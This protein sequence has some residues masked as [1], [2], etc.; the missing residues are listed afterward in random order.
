MKD[1]A[2]T[3]L[4]MPCFGIRFILIFLSVFYWT[5]N[6]SQLIHDNVEL[7]NGTYDATIPIGEELVDKWGFILFFWHMI[8]WLPSIIFIPPL[9]LPLTMV[10]TAFTVFIAKA[11][12][13]QIGYT[14][15]K[16]KACHDPVGL[17]LR[18]PP[19]TNESFFAAAGRLNETVASPTQMCV[20]FVKEMQTGIACW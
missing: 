3:A 7:H 1:N 9:N 13:Y 2:Y 18:R 11:I 6:H 15:Q 17:E 12:H 10:D 8:L 14:P 4:F 20:E 19:G 16:L 5:T